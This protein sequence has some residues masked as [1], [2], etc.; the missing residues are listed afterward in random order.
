MPI[1]EGC[2]FSWG[3]NT[4]SRDY[5]LNGHSNH[6]GR[7]KIFGGLSF[8][9]VYTQTSEQKYTSVQNIVSSRLLLLSFLWAHFNLKLLEC[10]IVEMILLILTASIQ[11]RL[12][13][14]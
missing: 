2:L 9:W 6:S 1:F 14:V 5:G 13:V 12:T 7:N 4:V 11:Y 8:N 3:A 10:L